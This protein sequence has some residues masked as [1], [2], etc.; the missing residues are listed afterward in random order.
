MGLQPAKF[1]MWEMIHQ[2]REERE[3]A[4][5]RL[6][7]EPCQL[8]YIWILIWINNKNFKKSQLKKQTSRKTQ[9]SKNHTTPQQ[10]KLKSKQIINRVSVNENQKQ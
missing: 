9:Q 7:Y 10:Q 4:R 5:A 6:R 1:R 3:S 8:Q 2:E